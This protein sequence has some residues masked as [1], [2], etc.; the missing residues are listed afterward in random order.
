MFHKIIYFVFMMV[1]NIELDI[2]PKTNLD[3]ISFCIC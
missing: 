3:T 1:E 2:F